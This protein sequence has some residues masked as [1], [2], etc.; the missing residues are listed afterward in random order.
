MNAPVTE[1][2]VEGVGTIRH[3][4]MW[5]IGAMRKCQGA[6]RYIA[7][8][9]FSAGMT[10]RQFKRLSPELQEAAR[11]AYHRLTSP[12]N[13]VP[14][15]EAQAQQQARRLPRKGEHVP[16]EKQIELGRRLIEMKKQLPRGH[17][18]LWLEEKS[19]LCKRAAQR[20]MRAAKEAD[21]QKRS[22]G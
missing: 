22:A 21:Q 10:V 19:G 17:F 18:G 8:F 5:Q 2:E 16:E 20:F 11:Q 9:A 15:P 4:N 1:I 7:P 13:M 12:A 3:L 6:N 14:S